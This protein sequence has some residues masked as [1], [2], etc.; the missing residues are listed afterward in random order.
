MN[1]RRRR[2]VAL[3]TIGIL[4][5][6]T[7]VAAG[8]WLGQ[9][10]DEQPAASGVTTAPSTSPPA[11][12]GPTQTT[13]IP[14]I[15]VG[16]WK[17]L[18]AAPVPAGLYE[19]SGVWSGRELLLYG[20][21]HPS[22]GA[23]YGAG[24]AYNP[25]TNTWRKLPPAPFRA[26]T[27]EGGYAT[28]WTG[29]EMLGQGLGLNVAY[30]PTTNR[31][32]GI[33]A[34]S[35]STAVTAWTGRQALSWGGGCCGSDSAEGAAYTP[36]TNSRQQLPPAPL[37]GRH[38]SGAWTG[39]E[40][41]IVGG[42]NTD[43]KIFADAAAYN[44][45][46]R[47][48]R[49]LPPL[50]APRAAATATWTGTEV[51]VVGGHHGDIAHGGLYADGVAYNPATNRWRQLPSMEVG[52]I[53]HSAVW[54][55]RQLLVWGGQTVRAGVRAAPPHGLAYDP[56]A[57]RWSALPAAPLRGRTGHLAVWTGSQMLV[58]GGS[59]ARDPDPGQRFDNGAAY[60]PAG[61]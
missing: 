29:S 8:W 36:A 10:G 50:P 5:A 42:N 40:L 41:V 54:T 4:V 28:V 37:A 45:T 47:T 49:R 1:E 30:D 15:T 56:A 60:R 51:L 43:G 20:V 19:Y 27:M 34:F 17:R 59:A 52:R 44:P 16:T 24:A 26:E 55:G 11:T 33:P 48:W 38:T 35:D 22:K 7:M 57:N 58:W 25:A 9:R 12:G 14:Q 46:T 21:V 23:P 2:V 18:P 61:L 39:R 13:T 32:R 31:W 6:A 3:T 53:G